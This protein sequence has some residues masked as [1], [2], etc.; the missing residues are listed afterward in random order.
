[1]ADFTAYRVALLGTDYPAKYDAFITA[2]QTYM[3][4]LENGREG[5]ASLAANFARY[6]QAGAGLTQNLQSN[7]FTI[8]EL[9]NPVAPDHVVNKAYA[10]ALAFAS[11]LP[12]ISMDTYGMGITNDGATAEWGDSAAEASAV[13][14]A[15]FNFF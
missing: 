10:D 11:A 5:Q 15:W 4:E 2:M 14:N 13:L 9:P 7:G 6:I 12:S 3:T 8:T 1:M